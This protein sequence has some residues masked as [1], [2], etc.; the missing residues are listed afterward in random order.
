MDLRAL[1]RLLMIYLRP[2]GG[3]VLLLALLLMLNLTLLL[4]NPQV[5]RRFLDE[6]MAG[7]PLPG[8]AATFVGLALCQQLIAASSR[9]LAED[10]GWKATNRLR[11]DLLKHVL[12][13]DL[14]F[15]KAHTPGDLVE[16]IDGDVALLATFFSRMLIDLASN[17]LLLVGIL[18]LLLRE[19]WRAGL[20]MALFAFG[21][22]GLLAAIRGLAMPH[23]RALRALVGD[24]FGFVGEVLTAREDLRAC[25]A[26]P[27]VMNRFAALQRRWL[28]AA[29]QARV[30][31]ISL[32]ATGLT[33]VALGGA[34]ALGVGAY[35]Y[36]RGL[37]TLG[38]VYLILYYTELMSQPIQ[39]MRQQVQELQSAGAGIGR[40]Q[41]LLALPSSVEDG[42]AAGASLPP[43]ALAVQFEGVSFAYEDGGPVLRELSFGLAPGKV[44]GL[45]GRTG[46]G[47]TTISRLLLRLCN[48]TA[49]IVRLSGLDTRCVDLHHLRQRVGMVTQEVQLLAATVRENLTLFDLSVSDQRLVEVL[50]DLGLG[51][52]LAEQPQGLDTVL[53]GGGASLSAGEAQLL[54]FARVFLRDPGLVILDEAAA[55]LDPATEARIERA[56]DRLLAGRTAIIIAHRP[57]SVARADQMLTLEEVAA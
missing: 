11:R 29:R 57:S 14:R 5:L 45:M 10:V 22:M 27:Y 39:Q 19:D 15:H 1:G 25:G 48:P 23:Y 17:A 35:L 18:L 31:G 32:W 44:L 53:V 50:E 49:G 12:H 20:T 4:M 51:A 37:A 34:L 28:P 3:R 56:I 21:A 47:K 41:E 7:R 8:V 16:R 9:Y 55:R 54:A 13:L 46:S 38:T 52:W 36:S 40:V 43:G 24:F 33:L 2:Q 26:E 6:A 42:A 30:R